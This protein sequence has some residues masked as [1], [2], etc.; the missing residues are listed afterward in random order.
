MGFLLLVRPFLTLTFFILPGLQ[1]G[2]LLQPH[3]PI[4]L[5]ISVRVNTIQYVYTLCNVMDGMH[6]IQR[7]PFI[8]HTEVTIRDGGFGEL[9]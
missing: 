7:I 5:S 2:L 8:M 1:Q 3:T 9:N 4:Y 6:G